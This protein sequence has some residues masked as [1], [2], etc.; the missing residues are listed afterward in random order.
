MS[1]A[2]RRLPWSSWS[3]RIAPLRSRMPSTRARSSLAPSSEISGWTMNVVSYS[4]MTPPW[5][6][7]GFVRA[8]R[9]RRTEVAWK[10]GWV[11]DS[12]GEHQ[13][14]HARVVGELGVEGGG[15]YVALAHEHRAPLDA[16]EHL[17]AALRPELRAADEHAAEPLEPGCGAR[18][19][20]RRERVHLRSVGV[21][22]RHDVEQAERRD[23]RALHR[24]R[25]QD[26]ARAG[27]EHR[28][29][30]RREASDRIPELLSVH[31]LRDRG[32]LAARQDQRVQAGEVCLAQDGHG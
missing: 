27:A 28:P 4:R 24:A 8:P 21:P 17:H 11:A 31:P 19:H 2:S 15:E 32:A 25:E 14:V 5:T 20:R 7:E 26:R 1:K 12:A 3:S 9:V 13:R 18:V 10:A 6:D 30:G 23:R 16:R 29:A 22:H